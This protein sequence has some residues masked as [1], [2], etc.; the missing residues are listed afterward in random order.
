MNKHE[1]E[2]NILEA[3]AWLKT[4]SGIN[5]ELYMD[6][7]FKRIDSLLDSSDTDN[8]A[9]IISIAK[10]KTDYSTR[11]ERALE[12]DSWKD[13]L[14]DHLFDPWCCPLGCGDL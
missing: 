10:D 6:R 5:Y 13:S 4:S 8:H 2:E 14:C 3:D 12:D 11:E 1:I 7:L 9:L